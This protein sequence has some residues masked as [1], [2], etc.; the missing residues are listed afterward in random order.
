[1]AVAILACCVWS[2][3]CLGIFT[4]QAIGLAWHVL[5]SNG[6]GVLLR[7]GLLVGIL[8]KKTT[9]TGPS[10]CSTASTCTAPQT[11]PAHVRQVRWTQTSTSTQTR[12]VLAGS[13]RRSRNSVL[14]ND[15]GRSSTRGLSTAMLLSRSL[16]ACK[17]LHIQMTTFLML[18]AQ[19]FA[20]IH[21]LLCSATRA[22]AA[23]GPAVDSQV[24]DSPVALCNADL[25]SF[26]VYPCTACLSLHQHR[27]HHCSDV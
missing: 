5:A 19:S 17:V 23:P 7:Q 2:G 20:D 26:C 18:H 4:I 11:L 24:G 14:D 27:S 1:V 9:G 12:S 3:N 10:Y 21:S 6:A 25:C 15:V 16:N 8:V 13:S 22:T